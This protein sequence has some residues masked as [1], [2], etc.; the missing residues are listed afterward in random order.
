MKQKNIYTMSY[1]FY[2]HIM[3]YI[4]DVSFIS[5][6]GAYKVRNTLGERQDDGLPGE[7]QVFLL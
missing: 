4:H 7:R 3:S 5:D 2:L 6:V 1:L